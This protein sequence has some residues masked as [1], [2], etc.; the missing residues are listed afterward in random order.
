MKEILCRSSKISRKRDLTIG[1]LEGSLGGDLRRRLFRRELPRP[2]D[3]EDVSIPDSVN[4][5]AP[6]LCSASLFS[7]DGG[8]SIDISIRIRICN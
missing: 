8:V 3:D 2:P 1:S 5:A 4:T 7:F 6:T